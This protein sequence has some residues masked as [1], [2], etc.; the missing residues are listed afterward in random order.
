MDAHNATHQTLLDV[1]GAPGGR[2]FSSWCPER[3]GR[4]GSL[5]DDRPMTREVS[6]G[7]NTLD[8]RRLDDRRIRS[9]ELPS[10]V[11]GPPSLLLLNILAEGD[12]DFLLLLAGHG[13]D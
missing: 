11:D 10:Q 7:T 2:R 5:L 9:L 4:L 3:R 1:H 8:A 12:P 13:S 6:L